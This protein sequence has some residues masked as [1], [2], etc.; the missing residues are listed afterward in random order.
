MAIFRRP[1]FTNPIPNVPFYSPTTN[2]LS[3][4]GG[5]LVVGAGITIDYT[6]STISA[7]GGGGSGSVTSITAGS[8]LTANGA[9]GG[10][11][12]SAGTL[13]LENTTVTAGSYTFPT[14]TVDVS[15][16]ITTATSNS[17]VTSVTAGA[18]LSGGTITGTGTISLPDTGVVAGNYDNA[19][20]TVD[21]KGRVTSATTGTAPVTAV[22]A[23]APLSSTGGTTPGISLQTSGVTPGAYTNTSLTV[24]AFGRVSAASSGAA[25]ITAITGTAPIAAVTTLGASVV[26]VADASTT[27]KGAV[28]LYDNV[29]STSTT[30]ALTAAQG[31]NLQSQ[32]TA[33]V[34]SPGIELAGTIDASTGFMVSVTSVGTAAGYTVGAV[35]P[36]ASATTVNSYAI[37]TTAGTMTPPGGSPVAATTGDWFLVSQ[38]SPGVYSWGFLNVGFD[39]PVATTSV[40]GIVCL[41]TNALAEAGT[42]TTTALT[43]AAAACA[44]RSCFTSKGILIS[45]TAAC[46]PVA[47]TVGANGTI[48]TACS[49]APS[50]LCWAAISV[51]DATPIAAGTVLG[52]TT[53]ASTAIG[54][55]AA[56]ASC[57]VVGTVAVGS[58]ALASNTTCIGNTAVGASALTA[59]VAGP[60]NTAL[61]YNT[62]LSSNSSFNT[63]VG[64]LALQGTTSGCNNV[65][66]GYCAGANLTTGCQ[67]A[68]I[69]PQVAAPSA[70]GSNQLAIGWGCCYWLT[71]DA[72]K[73]IRPGA[74]VQDCTGSIGTV[75]QIMCSTGSG[76]LW[77]SIPSPCELLSAK[78][79]LITACA[80]GCP[81]ELLVGDNAKVLTA[82]STCPLGIKWNEIPTATPTALGLI[83]G[84]TC[85]TN[86]S[87]GCNANS[88]NG[89]TKTTAIGA[90]ALGANTA[91]CN[92]A[93][94]AASLRLATTGTA[95]VAVGTDAMCSLTTGACNTVI[96]HG[97][98][99]CAQTDN[100][101]TAVGYLAL[102]NVTGGS[103]NTALGTCAGANLTAGSCNVAIGSNANVACATGSCQLAIG[104]SATC[105]WLIGDCDKNIQP[106]AGILDCSSCVGDCGQI[107]SSTA[108]GIEW[109]DKLSGCTTLSN[110]SLGCNS[111]ANTGLRNTAIGGLTLF[112][113]TVGEDNV[114]VGAA[115]LRLA[116]DSCNVAIGSFALCK[117]TTGGENT[118]VGYEAGVAQTTGNGTTAVGSGA[119]LASISGCANT[120]LGVCAGE[121][122]TTGS[123]N[124][125][126]GPQTCVASGTASCQ[127]AI[128]IGSGFNWLTGD[129]NKN[130]RPGAGIL[131]CC[132]CVGTANQVLT[133]TA[134]GIRWVT[135][136]IATPTTV[137]AVYG[138]VCC[139]SAAVGFNAL[140]CLTTGTFN[141]ALGEN[142]G[143]KIT[144]G[145]NNIAIGKNALCSE[146]TGSNN[147]AIGKDALISAVG[148]VNNVAIGNSAGCVSITGGNVF[149]GS[150]AGLNATTGAR[151]TMIGEQAG[152]SVTTGTCNTLLGWGAGSNITTTSNNVIIGPG[153]LSPQPTFDSQLKIGVGNRH[154]IEGNQEFSTF[155]GGNILVPRTGQPLSA[156]AAGESGI[157]NDTFGPAGTGATLILG[158]SG[159]GN[160]V[161]ARFCTST[162]IGYICANPSNNG[163]VY[164]TSSDYRLKE[165]AKPV[166]NAT[167]KL[168]ALPVYEYNYKGYSDYCEL[169]FFAHELQEAHPSL[170]GGTKDQV[171][172]D[173]NPV[174]QAVDYGRVTPLLAAALKESIARIDALEKKVAELENK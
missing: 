161:Y 140:K 40:A 146:T 157:V 57:G 172:E 8:G 101:A 55:C 75:G 63:A 47:L 70:T 106:G 94:G 153:V 85:L 83:L 150:T 99:K 56:K 11:I 46:A 149:I 50:G 16:R 170:A 32:I 154:W 86:V 93:V 26:S 42:D 4:V 7:P 3:S 84:C 130:I 24:D 17:A 59:S 29:D 12:T 87:L 73:N 41:S 61:G 27:A 164:A 98:G 139:N 138:C 82:D 53:L 148:Q 118:V 19:T 151:Q 163:V 64:A 43:P 143:C 105:N 156:L 121:N 166:E 35:L 33:L 80:A 92:V 165:N 155:F 39:A 25:P 38:V 145:N 171:N 81:R 102:S 5:Q 65:A 76:L 45:A 77:V 34:T 69:G 107:L 71:G 174:Y 116:D 30:L 152:Q 28:Q 125:A 96:G 173:G 88:S 111:T 89:G 144:T 141:V 13:A 78:G 44:A 21:V 2:A 160:H 91:D 23:A 14:L 109:I 128:G 124:V 15:G 74:G 6:T 51:S 95:N 113:N 62:L 54:C 122:I 48:L 119:L 135:G 22:T 159:G 108:T 168:T 72:N 123:L 115:A 58:N 131:D 36:A 127:L 129:C 60:G 158:N 126:I 9:P 110:T 142:T 162:Q 67:N 52:Q 31:K 136:P 20:I 79:S 1:S 134:T 49:T 18:G 103:D 117:L 104:F 137:G 100:S 90:Q 167:E 169:G 120:A 133:S 10:V 132:G 147:I 66:M 37:V 112:S 68:F 97:A 114:A